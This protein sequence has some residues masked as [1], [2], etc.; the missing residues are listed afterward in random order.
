MLNVPAEIYMSINPARRARPPPAV[1]RSALFAAFL[2]SGFS[3]SKPIRKKEE[4]LVN[5]QKINIV[6]KFP[7][8]TNPSI[9]VKNSIINK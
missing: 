9:E 3:L 6:I 4:I 2:A 7:D 8:V 1:T 5:S